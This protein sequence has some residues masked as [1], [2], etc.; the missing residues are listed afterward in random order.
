[1]FQG[2]L[3][4]LR[5][6]RLTPKRYLLS[7]TNSRASDL[8]AAAK[9][10]KDAVKETGG[11]VHV[12]DG[13]SFYIAAASMP[14][15]LAAEEAGD[16][17][18]MLDAGAKALPVRHF[19]KKP[20]WVK[21]T[22]LL[23]RTVM[24]LR[25]YLKEAILTRKSTQSGCGPCIGLGTGL[26]E[27]GEVGISASNRK[28]HL[29]LANSNLPILEYSL[30]IGNFKGRMGSAEAKAYLASPEV[31]ASSALSGTISGPGW[32]QRPE[33]LS[34]VAIGEGQGS[35]GEGPQLMTAEEA[36]ER[37][38][39]QLESHIV[40]AEKEILS[41][42]PSTEKALVPVLHGFPERVEGELSS[43]FPSPLYLYSTRSESPPVLPPKG[44]N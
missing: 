42:A 2:L 13:V 30:R 23:A 17:Q 3:Y 26:L 15:Q 32:Y 20:S 40:T 43:Y 28:A 14:E 21:R 9:V 36:L 35:I 31:V 6:T 16:W 33:G 5:Q 39:G 19:L 37:V 22:L 4:P 41:E 7:C 11:P 18:A 10:F 27:S 25:F 24:Q 38:I 34:G 1:M 29:L 12:A 8:A 44:K